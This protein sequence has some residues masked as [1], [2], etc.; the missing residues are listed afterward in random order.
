M[1]RDHSLQEPDRQSTPSSS[2]GRGHVAAFSEQLVG[3]SSR[4]RAHVVARTDSSSPILPVFFAQLR[5]FDRDDVTRTRP[6]TAS[7]INGS[8]QDDSSRTSSRSHVP[9]AFCASISFLIASRAARQVPSAD[10][11][12]IVLAAAQHHKK[13]TMRIDGHTSGT[14]LFR[15][16]HAIPRARGDSSTQPMN[17]PPVPVHDCP[18]SVA[19]RETRHIM[20]VNKALTPSVKNTNTQIR[21]KEHV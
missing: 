12:L 14:Q 3:C 10:V 13:Q 8:F 19:V 1:R 9:S 18:F 5:V 2:D 15:T 16:L 20:V 11:G 21:L 6:T 7:G 17:T 4:S